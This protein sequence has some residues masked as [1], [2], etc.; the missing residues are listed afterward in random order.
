M[1]VVI[2]LKNYNKN[3]K[4]ANNLKWKLLVTAV[5]RILNCIAR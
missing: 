4:A 5:A 2:D 1:M 3:N